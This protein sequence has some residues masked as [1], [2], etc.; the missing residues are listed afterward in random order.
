MF[1]WFFC[2]NLDQ[3][4]EETNLFLSNY[5]NYFNS[6]FLCWVVI[7]G[8]RERINSLTFYMCMLHYWKL[9]FPKGRLELTYWSFITSRH[10]DLRQDKGSH[11][12]MTWR[13]G[14]EIW[15]YDRFEA[16]HRV[17]SSLY[18]TVLIYQ[19]N[20][21]KSRTKRGESKHLNISQT[22]KTKKQWVRQTDQHKSSDVYTLCE[23]SM[24]TMAKTKTPTKQ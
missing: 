17:D 22:N 16:E 10:T 9:M 7:H 18:T 1:L 20:K 4:V 19:T 14:T 8:Q 5:S 21:A 3:S 23:T 2:D 12:W 6:V 11:I 13:H 15:G 24:N